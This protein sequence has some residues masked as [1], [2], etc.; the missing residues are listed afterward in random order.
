MTANDLNQQ[1]I[2]FSV[3]SYKSLPFTAMNRIDAYFHESNAAVARNT[4][5]YLESSYSINRSTVF[6]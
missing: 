5:R 3:Q 1:T 2:S 6:S 4:D